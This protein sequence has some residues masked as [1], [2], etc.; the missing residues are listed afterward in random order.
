MDGG[1]DVNAVDNNGMQPV[2]LAMASVTN[3]GV[4]RCPTP[5]LRAAHATLRGAD[6]RCVR[7]D[8]C[9]ACAN[10]HVTPTHGTVGPSAH[11][12]SRKQSTPPGGAPRPNVFS[13]PSLKPITGLTDIHSELSNRKNTQ[14]IVYHGVAKHVNNSKPRPPAR[15]NLPRA[16]SENQVG[17]HQRRRSSQYV[18]HAWPAWR[19]IAAHYIMASYSTMNTIADAT[20]N[21]PTHMPAGTR[22]RF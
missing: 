14:R 18:R 20:E 5:P 12:A 19:P 22:Q 11:G 3:D 15:G 17:P 16:P 8:G 13:F 6:A 21:G 4:W 2:D 9:D 1:A 7:R 10:G